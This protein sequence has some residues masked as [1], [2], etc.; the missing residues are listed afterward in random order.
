MRKTYKRRLHL[1]RTISPNAIHPMIKTVRPA[2][3]RNL[4]RVYDLLRNALTLLS[5]AAGAITQKEIARLKIG[6]AGAFK[7]RAS[8]QMSL[9]SGYV[10]SS[11]FGRSAVAS[12]DSMVEQVFLT[13]ASPSMKR[14]NLSS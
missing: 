11:V 1:R 4:R 6:S 14:S 10:V 12:Q 8:S 5:K 2:M 13:V 7:W 3:T 9:R